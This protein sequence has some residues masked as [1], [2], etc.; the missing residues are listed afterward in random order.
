MSVLDFGEWNGV[1]RTVAGFDYERALVIATWP[2]VEV[3]HAY[4]NHARMRAHADYRQAVMV[5]ATRRNPK[6]SPPKFP[7]I[8]E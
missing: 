7:A 3:M 2:L 4:L 5:F 8:L 6:A 1:V